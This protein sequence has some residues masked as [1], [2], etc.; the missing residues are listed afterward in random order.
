LV[1]GAGFAEYEKSQPPRESGKTGQERQTQMRD[2]ARTLGLAADTVA[3]ALPATSIV[4]QAGELTG[5]AAEAVRLWR[6]S[7]GLGHGRYWARL[8]GVSSNNKVGTFKASGTQSRSS[9]VSANFPATHNAA[10]QNYYAFAAY[11]DYQLQCIGKGFDIISY[12][13]RPI[14]FDGGF[15]T[16]AAP[17]KAMG[18]CTG[19]R[20]GITV[21]KETTRAYQVGGGVDMS[22]LIGINLSAQTGYSVQTKID[23]AMNTNGHPWCG[24]ADFP[25]GSPQ[26]L[27]IHP[28]IFT[29]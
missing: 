4:R 29:G 3:G 18:N 16:A 10:Y 27:T 8:E 20:A 24:L 17:H 26:L 11:T 15:T 19:V 13:T 1:A 2:M 7:S 28:S 12:E 5:Q 22:T 21:T 9:T 25:G 14:G 23:F 6:L